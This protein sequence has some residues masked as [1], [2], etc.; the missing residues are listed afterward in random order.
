MRREE[1]IAAIEKIRKHPKVEGWRDEFIQVVSKATADGQ[2]R[3]ASLSSDF[4]RAFVYLFIF[5]AG[6]RHI[7]KTHRSYL[8]PNVRS[9]LMALGM[10]AVFIIQLVVVFELIQRMNLGVYGGVG[11]MY[12][13]LME[14]V[15]IVWILTKIQPRIGGD[16]LGMHEKCIQCKYDLAGHDSVLGD[17]LWVGPA[18]CPECGQQYPAVS[19]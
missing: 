2:A 14:F 1:V 17:K 12:L 5:A 9:V 4:Q 8:K 19:E 7:S 6:Y 11:F 10:L 13:M 15:G 18:E 3:R 16:E